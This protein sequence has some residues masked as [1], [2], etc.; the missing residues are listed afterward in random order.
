M[1]SFG[2]VFTRK[3]L[4]NRI[5]QS[6]SEKQLAALVWELEDAFEYYFQADLLQQWKEEIKT[7]I[8]DEEEVGSPDQFKVQ[9]SADTVGKFIYDKTKVQGVLE[10]EISERDFAFIVD[11][12]DRAFS[13]YF[14]EETE[15]LWADIDVI[16]EEYEQ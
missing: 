14:N 9:V 12:F 13:K 6:L 4:E 16:V 2:I 10:S 8:P 1:D 11:Y 15:R 3:D 5:G 7:G